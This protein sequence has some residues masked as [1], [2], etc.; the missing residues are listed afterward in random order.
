MLRNLDSLN[1]ES[2]ADYLLGPR[3]YGTPYS[4]VLTVEVAYDSL[5]GWTFSGGVDNLNVGCLYPLFPET[6]IDA[7]M[8]VMEGITVST[9]QVD[10]NHSSESTSFSAQGVIQLGGVE[11]DLVFNRRSQS[12]GVS[13]WDLPPR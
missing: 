1:F 11:L 2:A 3:V 6:Q 10:F 5:V 7:I 13:E 4:P 12:T 8:N 9:L